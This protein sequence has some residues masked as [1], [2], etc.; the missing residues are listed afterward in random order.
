MAVY[1]DFEPRLAELGRDLAW[2]AKESG[3]S[4]TQLRLHQARR[5]VAFTW[6]ALDRLCRTLCCHPGQILFRGG[7]DAD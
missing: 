7:N 2:L 6:E 4:I 3:V 5:S 1:L